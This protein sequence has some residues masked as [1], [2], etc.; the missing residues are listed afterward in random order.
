MLINKLQKYKFL[1]LHR[2]IVEKREYH[3]RWFGAYRFDRVQSPRH[4]CW[5][6]TWSTDGCYSG[7]HRLPTV[8]HFTPTKRG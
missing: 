3:V 1:F 2:K 4:K 7:D 8:G 6:H 5:L